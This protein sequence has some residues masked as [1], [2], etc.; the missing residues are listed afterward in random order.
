MTVFA[1]TPARGGSKGVP[2]KNIKPLAGKPLVQH[3]IEAARAC[4]LI[5]RYVVNTEDPEI[6]A[7]AE[8]LGVETQSRPEEFWHDNTFQEVDRLLQWAVA[9][10]EAK[11]ARINVVVLL[12]PTSPLRRSR[13]ITDCIDLVLNQGFDS[14]LTLR[15]DRSYIW[16]RE[17]NSGQV[18]PVNYD[19]AKRGPNQLEGW[20]QWIENKAV[21]AMRR[22]LL[23]ETGCRL[24]GRVGFVEM[25]KL[26]SIDIDRPE[27]FDLAGQIM[28]LR[29]DGRLA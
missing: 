10:L 27:D 16:R 29:Q 5:D 28:E 18:A 25:S 17:G 11:G 6:R 4:P 15:E 26:D 14:A 20:N 8:G 3:T 23:M 21:Y 12:Y 1:I 7:V 24:G 2:R 22:D 9:D 19:P 13:H